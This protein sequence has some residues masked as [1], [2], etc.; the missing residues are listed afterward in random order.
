MGTREIFKEFQARGGNR[1]VVRCCAWVI[2][3][4]IRVCAIKRK[5]NMNM[6]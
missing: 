6:F 4:V 3:G 5:R 1:G 2:V